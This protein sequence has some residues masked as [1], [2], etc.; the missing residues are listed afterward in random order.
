ME[1]PEDV[2]SEI[3]SRLPAKSIFKFKS[4]C[5][6]ISNFTN[7]ACFA[8]KQ[9]QNMMLKGNSSL[10]IQ[11]RTFLRRKTAYEL[12]GNETSSSGIPTKFLQFLDKRKISIVASS[13]GLLLCLITRPKLVLVLFICNPATQSCST[14]AT[15]ACLFP[16]VEFAFVWNHSTEEFQLIYFDQNPRQGAS[17]REF[18]CKVYMPKEGEW[19]ER[20]SLSLNE[21]RS[22]IYGSHVFYNGNIYFASCFDNSSYTRR[23]HFMSSY[24]FETGVTRRVHYPE[25]VVEIGYNRPNADWH[26]WIDIFNWGKAGTSNDDESICV[27]SLVHLSAF[28]IWVLTDLESSSWSKFL[29]ISFQEMGLEEDAPVV[30]DFKIMNGDSLVFI[31]WSTKNVYV[32]D[33]LGAK[34]KRLEKIGQLEADQYV[35]II[36]LEKIGQLEA[37]QYVSIIPYSSTL[38]SCGAGAKRFRYEI[39]K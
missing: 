28:T 23:Y 7:N 12:P 26:Y 19:K 21:D 16:T 36:R 3:F 2:I 13:N 6:S 35:S 24:N 5:K 15:P 37:D 22:K 34:G 25:Q 32:Y 4:C 1:L 8:L 10:V 27:V 20:G 18:V 29:S 17:S 30:Y 38:R 9:A 11:G 31:S 39:E 14:I 33:L